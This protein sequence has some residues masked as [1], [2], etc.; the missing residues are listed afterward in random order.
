MLYNRIIAYFKI[1]LLGIFVTVDVELVPLE[2]TRCFPVGFGAV[3]V[4]VESTNL[5]SFTIFDIRIF[6]IFIVFIVIAVFAR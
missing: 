6:T 2:K 1:V 3:G 5:S 4:G